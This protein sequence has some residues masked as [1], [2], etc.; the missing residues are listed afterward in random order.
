[1]YYLFII[2][3]V[4]IHVKQLL[5]FDLQDECSRSYTPKIINIKTLWLKLNIL[6]IIIM[7]MF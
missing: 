5:T 1:V 4:A 7:I 2:F 3:T 6:M